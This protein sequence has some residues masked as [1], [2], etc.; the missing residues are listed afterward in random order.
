[1]KVLDQHDAETTVT[2]S[3]AVARA[4][5][6]TALVESKIAEAEESLARGDLAS[7]LSLGS[8]LMLTVTREEASINAS[9]ASAAAANEEQRRTAKQARASFIDVVVDAA[10]TAATVLREKPAQLLQ[11][12]K[13]VVAATGGQVEAV[14]QRKAAGLLKEMMETSLASDQTAAEGTVDEITGGVSNL[15]ANTRVT[16]SSEADDAESSS[17]NNTELYATANETC[18]GV[19]RV[20]N[21]DKFLDEDPTVVNAE[22]VSM[23]SGKFSASY[24]SC[25]SNNIIPIV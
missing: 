4:E 23:C 10:A 25:L 6:T 15:L 7:A 13:S 9:N 22:H 8:S 2:A 5:V 11:V 20:M 19:M 1:M 24:P 17:A 18:A 3:I 14:A 16:T 21:K 12:I